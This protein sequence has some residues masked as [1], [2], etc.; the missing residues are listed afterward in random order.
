MYEIRM[1][2][3]TDAEYSRNDFNKIYAVYKEYLQKLELFKKKTETQK[4]DVYHII[5]E[6]Q[7][8]RATFLR[9]RKMVVMHQFFMILKKTNL[10]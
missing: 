10:L 5:T 4:V 6:Q 9:I 2:V 1:E 7:K 3:S 8:P